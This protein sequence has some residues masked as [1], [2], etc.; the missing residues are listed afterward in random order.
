MIHGEQ[1]RLVVVAYALFIRIWKE[2]TEVRMLPS[3]P[4]R[5]SGWITHRSLQLTRL[6]HG[7]DILTGRNLIELDIRAGCKPSSTMA[8]VGHALWIYAEL[9]LEH[10]A[11]PNLRWSCPDKNLLAVQICGRLY[12]LVHDD[13][14]VE[15]TSTH[16][17]RES[18]VAIITPIGGGDR[19][20]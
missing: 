20:G 19:Y 9:V 15:E 4:I 2:R 10:S 16:K 18:C 12:A 8:P 7:G 14:H 6:Q 13:V 11:I 5:C 3:V 1:T 17:D